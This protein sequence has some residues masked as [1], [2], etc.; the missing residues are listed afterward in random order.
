MAGGRKYKTVTREYMTQG[1]N[2]FSAL[3]KGQMLID[4]D[5]GVIMSGIVRKYLIGKGID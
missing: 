3:T 4:H 5:Y 2:G 1:H